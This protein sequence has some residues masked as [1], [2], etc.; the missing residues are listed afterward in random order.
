MGSMG[1]YVAV[2]QETRGVGC[3]GQRSTAPCVARHL[4]GGSRGNFPPPAFPAMAPKEPP[5]KI[6]AQKAQFIRSRHDGALVEAGMEPRQVLHAPAAGQ[7]PVTL[8]A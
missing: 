8:H 4:D 7:A 5:L 6:T 1:L 2:G 3:S